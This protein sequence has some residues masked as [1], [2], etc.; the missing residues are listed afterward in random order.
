MGGTMPSRPA[1]GLISLNESRRRGLVAE[2][3]WLVD[4]DGV[5][6]CYHDATQLYWDP[7]GPAPQGPKP[8]WRGGLPAVE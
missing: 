1:Y 6:R 4:D 3:A 8:L 2:A 7:A 5:T